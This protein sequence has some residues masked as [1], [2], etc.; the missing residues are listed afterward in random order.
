MDTIILHLCRPLW[1]PHWK[2][3]LNLGPCF[4]CTVSGEGGLLQEQ[5]LQ[6]EPHKLCFYRRN[7]KQTCKNLDGVDYKKEVSKCSFVM[8]W[9]ETGVIAVYCC[10]C[11]IDLKCLPEGSGSNSKCPV[12]IVSVYICVVTNSRT[13]LV[14][15]CLIPQDM[16]VFDSI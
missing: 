15:H 16:F 1:P 3:N 12:C 13:F 6:K 11:V 9:L 5:W 8:V 4:H 14:T 7:L 10:W 2:V